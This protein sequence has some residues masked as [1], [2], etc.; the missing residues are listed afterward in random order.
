MP[1]SLQ[2][3]SIVGTLLPGLFYPVVRGS[4][5]HELVERQ[6]SSCGT[7]PDWQPTIAAC[8]V[9]FGYQIA[10]I[11]PVQVLPGAL[12][13]FLSYCIGLRNYHYI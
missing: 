2:T 6:S 12:I 3:I 9:F 1:N 11:L 13:I 7:D 4:Q 5:E 8:K 10:N